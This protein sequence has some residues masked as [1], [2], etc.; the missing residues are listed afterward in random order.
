MDLVQLLIADLNVQPLESKSEGL[1][2]LS[3]CK[4]Q[5]LYYNLIFKSTYRKICFKA[6]QGY[7]IILM[8]WKRIYCN[9][10]EAPN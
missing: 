6:K 10:A 9:Q 5:K 4:L 8:L 3:T 7:N 1:K 2:W